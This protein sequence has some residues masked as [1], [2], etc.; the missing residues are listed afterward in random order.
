MAQSQE[1][2]PAEETLV[3]VSDRLVRTHLKQ[4]R[5]A[6]A[7][8]DLEEARDYFQKALDVEAVHLR[9]EDEIRQ[10]LKQYGERVS[11]REPPNWDLAYQGLD[12]LVALELQNDETDTWRRALKLKHAKYLLERKQQDE[13]FDIFRALI[14]EHE[15]STDRDEILARISSILRENISRRAADHEWDSL[16]NMIKSIEELWPPGDGL[17]QWLETISEALAVA[18]QAPAEYKEQLN[19]EKQRRQNLIYAVVGIFGLFYVV[20]LILWVVSS[21]GV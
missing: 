11:N 20:L 3:S 16:S 14:A 7:S 9:R 4:A 15:Q 21:G 8:D 5:A 2:T 19:Q 6:L 1:D 17:H 12:L 10:E 13:S 18:A